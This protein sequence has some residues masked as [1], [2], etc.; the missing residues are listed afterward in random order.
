M[1]DNFIFFAFLFLIY[2]FALAKPPF[3][4]WEKVFTD[5]KSDLRIRKDAYFLIQG[6]NSPRIY[7]LVF[8]DDLSKKIYLVQK[9][10]T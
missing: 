4:I 6:L 3:I 2:S 10:S 5:L 1:R 8:F 7:S 9:K